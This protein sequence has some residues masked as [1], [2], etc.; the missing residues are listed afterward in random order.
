MPKRQSPEQLL[1][2]TWSCLREQLPKPNS[3]LLICWRADCT[4]ALSWVNQHVPNPRVHAASLSALQQPKQAFPAIFAKW[5]LHWLLALCCFG[6]A[7]RVRLA[8]KQKQHVIRVLNSFQPAADPAGQFWLLHG[9]QLLTAAAASASF[10]ILAMNAS[11]VSELCWSESDGAS[12]LHCLAMLTTLS[13]SA[14]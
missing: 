2:R 5:L 13:N 12:H 7:S 6:D 14:R 8:C 9:S 3:A 11:S 1:L 4:L 10:Y